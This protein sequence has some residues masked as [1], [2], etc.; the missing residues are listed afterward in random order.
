M[1]EETPKE[2]EKICKI[3]GDKIKCEEAISKILNALK[4]ISGLSENEL[5]TIIKKATPPKTEEE[6]EVKEEDK[7]E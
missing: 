3:E 1:S 7:N 4:E 2:L 5:I 6:I